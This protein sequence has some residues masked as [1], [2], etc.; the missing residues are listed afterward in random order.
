LQDD[1]QAVV[2]QRIAKLRKKSGLTQDQFAEVTGLNR[3]HLYRLET[4]KQS[5]TLKTLKIV[6]DSLGVPVTKLLRGF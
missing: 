2:G 6:A 1:I 4:G 5:M 3:T